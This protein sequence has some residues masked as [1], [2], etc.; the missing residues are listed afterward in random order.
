MPK[1]DN[2]NIKGLQDLGFY[3]VKPCNQGVCAICEMVLREERVRVGLDAVVDSY[4][5]DHCRRVYMEGESG[6]LVLVGR[7]KNASL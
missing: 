5:C 3:K 4:I 1:Y 2:Q 7:K 6:L